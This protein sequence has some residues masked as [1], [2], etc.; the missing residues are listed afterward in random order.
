MSSCPLPFGTYTT[1]P[2]T[3][4]SW[5]SLIGPSC[6]LLTYRP[7]ASAPGHPPFGSAPFWPWRTVPLRRMT[8]S[9]RVD[10]CWPEGRPGSG[11]VFGRLPPEKV[12]FL[13]GLVWLENHS[14]QVEGRLLN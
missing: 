3:A 12:R 9:S 2:D 14:W 1:P 10:V 6:T 8:T 5:I 7:A 13:C 4:V 11:P